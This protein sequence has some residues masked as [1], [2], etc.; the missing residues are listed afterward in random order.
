MKRKLSIITVCYNCENLVEKTLTSLINQTYQDFEYIVIDG[1]SNDNTL[2]VIENYCK[3]L[4]NV[5]IKSEKDR[6]IYDAM[7]KG[8]NIASGEFIYFLNIGDEFYDNKVLEQVVPNL[9]KKIIYYGDIVINKEKV[10]TNPRKLST[11]HFLTEGMICHQSIFAPAETLKNNLFD[12]K[13]KYCADE[14][15]LIDSIKNKKIKHK[16]MHI[17]ICH[18]D[19]TGL[20]STNIK[21]VRIETRK[22]KEKYYSKILILLFDIRRNTLRTIKK[23]I[24]NIVK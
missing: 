15:W 22:V 11:Y 12:I 3:K 18:Y 17:K 21:E 14:N 10:I 8:I 13:Y 16:H 19:T 23:M 2:N 5:I 9:S 4:K 6:G 24:K 20:T 1:K 7:N